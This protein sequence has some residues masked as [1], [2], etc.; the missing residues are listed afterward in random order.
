MNLNGKQ[1]SGLESSPNRNDELNISKMMW[2][3][4]WQEFV[5]FKLTDDI[6]L[7][8]VSFEEAQIFIEKNF[9]EIFMLDGKERF[10][11]R[12]GRGDSRL[13][14]YQCLGE[15]FLFRNNIGEDIGVA[16]GTPLDW[17]AYNLRNVSILTSYQNNG[18]DSFFLNFLCS[19]LAKHAVKKIIG[20]IAPSNRHH[21]HIV[22]KIGFMV[23][24]MALD[25]E[26]GALLH[27]TK[28]LDQS[29][30]LRFG[31]LFCGSC[32][33]DQEHNKKFE[34]KNRTKNTTD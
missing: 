8:L 29:D 15:F 18:L 5:P 28:Y 26:F 33:S 25:D 13:K 19:V 27:V 1:T 4:D 20:D 16:I 14:Y 9:S 30:E 10:G 11:A 3:L 32:N 17:T 6:S 2:D 23:T 22:N 7:H 34:F 24:S 21:I 12:S 31:E